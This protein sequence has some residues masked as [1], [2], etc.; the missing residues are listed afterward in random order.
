MSKLAVVFGGSG[1]VGRNV[2]REL[3]KRGWRIRVAVRRP[4]LA[5]FLRPLGTVGQI[6]LAQ[7]NIRYPG[8][9]VEAMRGADAVINLA[10]ILAEHGPQKFDAIHHQGAVN[11]AHIAAQTGI[12]RFIHVSAIGADE[13][14]E[15]AYARSKGKAEKAIKEIL[16][17]ATIMRPSV[18]FGAEDKFFNRFAAMIR[19]PGIVPLIGG[20]RTKFQPVYVDDVAD[21]IC[22][23]LDKPSASGKIFELAGPNIYSFAELIEFIS[24]TIGRTTIKLPLPFPVA[25]LAGRL[26]DYINWLP[27]ISAPITSDQVRLLKQDN[28]AGP[29]TDATIGT[30]AD[31]GI[32]PDT[33]EAVM[34]PLLIR[35]RKFGQF[36]I[37]PA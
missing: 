21:A 9:I 24:H 6:Q 15:S 10:S 22:H 32:T 36:T 37:D 23:S 34:P 11:I 14:S 20:G 13:N 7:A 12:K 30:I 2:V 1:F 31:L 29:A 28:I 16:P 27:F 25:T 26:G 19:F 17:S 35:F 5:G 8:S 3:A 33:I 4:H 18:I